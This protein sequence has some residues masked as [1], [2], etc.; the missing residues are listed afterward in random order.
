VVLLNRL[1]RRSFDENTEVP[2]PPAD[3][4][5]IDAFASEETL[6]ASDPAA[7]DVDPQVGDEGPQVVVLDMPNVVSEAPR[8][9][10]IAA[11]PLWTAIGAVVVGGLIGAGIWAY[12]RSPAVPVPGTLTLQ[13]TPPGMQVTIAGKPAGTTPVTMS[14][15]AGEYRVQL[16]APDGRQRDFP[17]TLTAGGSVIREVEMA[18][19]APPPSAT[20]ALRVESEPSRQMVLVDGVE[21]GVS[22]VTVPELLA[23][24]HVV[25]VRT[26]AGNVRRTINVREGETVSLVV[27]GGAEAPAMRAGWVSFVSP[28]P[29]ELR[30]NGRVVGTSSVE[31][32]MLPAGDHE[33]EMANDALGY[34]AT[35][36]VT[37][38]ADRTT[39]I[40]V[41]LPNGTVSINATPWA[42]VWLGGEQ[43]GQ[44][45]I[46]N[47]SRPI[48]TYE[49]LLRHPQF[50]ERRARVTVSVKQTTRLGVDMRTP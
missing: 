5:G 26:A 23:G 27:S 38:A 11:L 45:P 37:I 46:A 22:P 15:P 12:Q 40:A 9:S 44:T 1:S 50:G 4:D 20:G 29:L 3:P 25:V 17:V 13:T 39:S 2:P 43:I 21:R 10:R 47:L 34:R 24:E 32:L 28:I 36:K 31:R 14:L 42:E 48:G 35:R 30:E 6:A 18:P 19:I 7:V 8:P 16:A 49:V 41:D 33:I